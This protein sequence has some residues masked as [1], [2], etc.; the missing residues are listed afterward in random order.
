MVSVASVL[1]TLPQTLVMRQRKLPPKPEMELM[2][3]AGMVAPE[4]SNVGVP[5]VLVLMPLLS[6]AH[7]VP[8]PA[9]CHC[10]QPGGFFHLL[11]VAG[12]W[13]REPGPGHVR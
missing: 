13:K 11:G 4:R 10:Q 7:A 3:I 1:V 2:F 6:A 9:G 5:W 12:A 8:G